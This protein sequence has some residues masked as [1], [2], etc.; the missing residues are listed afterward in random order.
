MPSK[1]TLSPNS[2]SLHLGPSYI[3]ARA[4]TVA[5]RCALITRLRSPATFRAGARSRFGRVSVCIPTRRNPRARDQSHRRRCRSVAARVAVA[6]SLRWAPPAVE[7]VV[8]SP[9]R[10]RRSAGI[11][12]R[13]HPAAAEQFRRR[14]RGGRAAPVPTM[15][16]TPGPPSPASHRGAAPRVKRSP[17]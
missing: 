3:V 15:R 10:R 12:H 14:R 2:W 11:P 1:L 13:V 7:H 6:I 5:A 9:Q 17:R 4:I 16:S 8:A